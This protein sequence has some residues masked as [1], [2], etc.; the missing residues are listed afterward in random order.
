MRDQKGDLYIKI[1]QLQFPV[2]EKGQSILVQ[3]VTYYS[4]DA[5]FN[6]LL[7]WKKNGKAY[8]GKFDEA[9]TWKPDLN[10]RPLSLDQG[11]SLN[12]GGEKLT[13]LENV[14]QTA[15]TQT[16]AFGLEWK[17]NTISKPGRFPQYFKK[18]GDTRMAIG[19]EEVPQPLREK[20]F[21]KA[22]SESHYINWRDGNE[23]VQGNFRIDKSLPYTSPTTGAWA[24]PGPS[25]ETSS[26]LLKDGSTVTYKWYKFVDQP[27]FQALGWTKEEKHAIQKF[28]EQIHKTWTIDQEYMAPPSTGK[29]VVIDPV[30]IVTPPSG[31]EFGYV[32]IVTK[33]EKTLISSR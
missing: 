22:G 30:L 8:S 26:V 6:Y 23:I 20:E 12:N 5:L 13:G 24:N 7:E 31:M 17:E 3:D 19:P 9:H 4:K 21:V 11:A 18:V 28:V 10:P 15:I 29:L 1:P 27:S 25:S 14:L 2:N 32:P 33:Q 16:N